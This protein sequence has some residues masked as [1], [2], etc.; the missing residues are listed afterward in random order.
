MKCYTHAK[1]GVD[2]EAVAVCAV[3][4]MALCMEHVHEREV[5]MVQRVSGWAGQTTMHI[6]CERCAKTLVTA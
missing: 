3:C 6:L 2:K 1:E 4:G 5:P